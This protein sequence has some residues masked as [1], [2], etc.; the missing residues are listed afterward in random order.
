MYSFPQA[1]RQQ[2][3][4]TSTTTELEGLRLLRCAQEGDLSGVRGL[5]SRGVDVN[6]QVGNTGSEPG[7]PTGRNQVG[8]WIT[9]P[10]WRSEK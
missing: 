8:E 7:S 4:T 2:A 3:N 6:F 10:R 5:L 1:S 9:R